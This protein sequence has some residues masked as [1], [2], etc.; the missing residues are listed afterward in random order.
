MFVRDSEGEKSILNQNIVKL[1]RYRLVT[2][3]PTPQLVPGPQS[4]SSSN[5]RANADGKVDLTTS[6]KITLGTS[7]GLGFP[8]LVATVAGALFAR[9]QLAKKKTLKERK[10]INQNEVTASPDLKVPGTQ[11]ANIGTPSNSV[12]SD[13]V[14]ATALAEPGQVTL[15]ESPVST[16]TAVPAHPGTNSLEQRYSFP[17]NQTSS[18]PMVSRDLVESIHDNPWL[19]L[20]L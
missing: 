18:E 10:E 20:E 15:E 11:E 4:S 5:A 2:I 7:I 14:D 19:K 9:R 1:R 17:L 6:D 13:S 16:R 12:K 3:D 8:A